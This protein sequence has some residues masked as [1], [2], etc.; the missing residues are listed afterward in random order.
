MKRRTFFAA[1]A[2]ALTGL[3]LPYRRSFSAEPAAAVP[4]LG[5]D[6]RQLTLSAADIQ[7][8]RAGLRGEVI[9][10]QS[11]NYDAA[12][13]LW[14]PSFDR[15]PALI[16]RC[17]GAGDVRRAVS[18]AASHG[19]L[20]TVRGGG[21]SLSGQSSID[22]AMVID[23]SPMRMV[24]V[25]PVAK[26]A[27]VAAGSLLGQLDLE[28]AQ[29]GLA[30]TAGTVADTGVAGL[31]L[32][33][34]V[35]RLGRKFGLTCDNV[36]GFELVTADGRWQ[37]ANASENPDLYWA[38]RGGGGNFGVVTSFEYQLH[39]LAPVIYGGTITYPYEHVREKLQAYADITAAAPDELDIDVDLEAAPGGGRDVTFSVCYCGPLADAE[40]AV[41]PLR[42]LGKPTEDKLGPA[43]Y[44][45]IQG[46]ANMPG[47]SD[48]GLH[49][50]GGFLPALTPQ[51]MDTI[52]DYIEHNPSDSFD[53]GIESMG[54]AISRVAPE[55]TAFF[56][57]GA[58][59]NMLAGGI[60]KVPGD[61]AERNSTWV[62]GAWKQL[63]PFTHG[64]YVNLA[65]SDDGE[66][67]ARAAYGDNYLRLADIKKRYDANNLFRFNANIKPA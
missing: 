40:K 26:R 62:R 48:M 16:V 52:I 50:K 60:W 51:L 19:L 49:I 15:R 27:R 66:S 53:I 12:R 21:H 33:G 34:G 4:I 14:I 37:R 8:L 35:G 1:G 6:G 46:S 29:F 25:D 17:A 30:T 32:G 61:G 11:K 42:K 5:L 24:E 45:K 58:R 31:T 67:R 41:A 65:N 43:S 20:T 39:E 56:H 22:N 9:T 54:G 13:R 28:T 3:A 23:L 2:A 10:A 63:E 64:H 36:V 18:F 38:L 57:R 47:Y 59:Y 44:V 55:A 7:D